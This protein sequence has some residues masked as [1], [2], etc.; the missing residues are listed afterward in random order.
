MGKSQ[1]VKKG[2]RKLLQIFLQEADEPF[3][4]I[5]WPC[6]FQKK[7]T[8]QTRTNKMISGTK[9]SVSLCV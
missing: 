2:N 5:D 7:K 1:L 4:V 9:I 3:H 6:C 8:E